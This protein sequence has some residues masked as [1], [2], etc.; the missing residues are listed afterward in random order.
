MKG[1]A[2]SLLFLLTVRLEI[3]SRYPSP[4]LH[5]DDPVVVEVR[6]YIWKLMGPIRGVL[7]PKVPRNLLN[8]RCVEYFERTRKEHL[9]KPLSQYEKEDGGEAAWEKAEPPAKEFAQLLKKHGGPFFLGKDGMT[10]SSVNTV[11][12]KSPVS[13]ADVI[14]VAYLHFMK[15]LDS[16]IFERY[17]AFDPA[18]Q[19]LYDASKQWLAKED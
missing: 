1:N 18:F 5:L 10:T 17:L 7:I 9:G 13:Y 14:F 11:A 19:E 6:D 3:E 12:N 4:S 8:E 2:G 16:Q 15:R